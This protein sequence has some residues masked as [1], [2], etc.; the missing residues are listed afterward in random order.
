MLTN[1]QIDVKR[2]KLLKD[3]ENMMWRYKDYNRKYP[4]EFLTYAE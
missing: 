4:P 1:E 2:K 3:T